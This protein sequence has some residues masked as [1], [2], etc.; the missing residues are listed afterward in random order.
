MF[1]RKKRPYQVCQLKLSVSMGRQPD[2]K[3]IIN[4]PKLAIGDAF[5]EFFKMFGSE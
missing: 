1:R 3:N 2:K 5:P 4:L